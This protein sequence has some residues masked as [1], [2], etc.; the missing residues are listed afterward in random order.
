MGY[1]FVA[2]NQTQNAGCC[3]LL[4]RLPA[5][6]VEI[7]AESILE[8]E[9]RAR[10]AYTN[11]AAPYILSIDEETTKSLSWEAMEKFP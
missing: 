11:L 8:R 9:P 1:Q 4:P 3:R 5:F 7:R 2:L 6:V 10:Q